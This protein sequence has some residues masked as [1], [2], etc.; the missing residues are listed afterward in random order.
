[1][2]SSP[3]YVPAPVPEPP[4]VEPPPVWLPTVSGEI[5][6][7][8]DQNIIGTT[9]IVSVNPKDDPEANS[10]YPNTPIWHGGDSMLSIFAFSGPAGFANN[11]GVHGSLIYNGGGHGDSGDNS[12]YAFDIASREWRRL[13][14]P[15]EKPQM[16]T[17]SYPPANFD[18]TWGDYTDTGNTPHQPHTYAFNQIVKINGQEHLFMPVSAAAGQQPW[19]YAGSHKVNLEADNPHWE[20]HILGNTPV[21]PAGY[22]AYDTLRNRVYLF[23]ATATTSATNIR[24]FDLNTGTFGTITGGGLDYAVVIESSGCYH[25]AGDLLVHAR[26]NAYDPGDIQIRFIRC[27]Q[28]GTVNFTTPTQVGTK[29]KNSTGSSGG[30]GIVYCPLDKALYMTSDMGIWKLSPPPGAVTPEDYRSGTWTWSQPTLSGENSLIT[31]NQFQ[32]K[33]MHWCDEYGVFI[34]MENTPPG[35]VWAFKP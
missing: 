25:E 27:D 9:T 4:L 6:R 34:G 8:A 30:M 14:N 20:R 26:S 22:T 16:L 3:I 31:F 10:N 5:R 23:T 28:L 18:I 19:N 15:H 35:A 1:M 2:R 21:G 29:A 12:V 17:A 33:M 13:V 11:I 32:Y 24:Y 7:I